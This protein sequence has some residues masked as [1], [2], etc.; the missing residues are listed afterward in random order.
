MTSPNPHNLGSLTRE[1]RKRL[2]HNEDYLNQSRT[3]RIELAKLTYGDPNI[4]RDW[5]M[6]EEAA[7]TAEN[8]WIRVML[9]DCQ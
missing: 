3:G 4:T 7:I 6:G 9:K 2:A 1:L 8:E 5:A